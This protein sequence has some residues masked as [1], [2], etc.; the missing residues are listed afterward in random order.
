MMHPELFG[1][2]VDIDGQ[3]GPTAGTKQQTIARLF[4]GDADAW[5]AFDP[6]TVIAKHSA[7]SGLSMR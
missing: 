7:Y 6:R 4:D 3:L 1:A 5:A 2:I